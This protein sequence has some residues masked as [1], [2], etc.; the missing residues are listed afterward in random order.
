MLRTDGESGTVM[1]T[2]KEFA[3]CMSKRPVTIYD[4]ISTGFITELGFIVHRDITG[5]IRIGVPPH[6]NA[7]HDFRSTLSL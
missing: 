5:C 1:L 6:H 7:Y 3:T 2:V 4:W